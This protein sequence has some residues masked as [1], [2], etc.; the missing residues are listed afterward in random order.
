VAVSK[1]LR[2]E[3]LRRD[4]HCC[5]YCGAKA[6]D[7]VLRVDHVVP[8]AL[9]GSDDPSNLVAACDPCNSGKSSVP[10]DAPLVADV[11]ADALR[12]SRAMARVAEIERQQRN[13]DSR[14]ALDFIDRVIAIINSD[15][16][17][18]TYC[19][20][21]L[22][23][24]SVG[25]MPGVTRTLAQFRDA[26]LDL[27]DLERAIRKAGTNRAISDQESWKYFCGIGWRMI[28]DRQDA[29]RALLS[30]EDGATHG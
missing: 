21:D 15:P 11:A 18:I 8:V 28:R 22:C 20:P 30:A 25:G 14:F 19:M 26:G 5:K 9:G 24:P 2:F 23:A 1:R 13:S 7:V 12:W 27:D 17:E 10:A 3:I 29:A 4:N 16:D 6:P